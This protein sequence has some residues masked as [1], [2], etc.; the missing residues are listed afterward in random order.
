MI[1]FCPKCKI[2]M[3]P[4]VIK[5]EKYLVCPKCGHKEKVKEKIILTSKLESK[6]ETKIGS[7]VMENLPIT[8]ITCP[9]CGNNEA[10][11]WLQQTRSADEPP[12]EFY[13]CTK[14]GYQWRS[15]G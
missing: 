2:L 9:K 10:Y 11:Y 1:K 3:R 8:K 5:N 4:Q 6:D 7:Q 12:T 13:K 15:Y 14:C